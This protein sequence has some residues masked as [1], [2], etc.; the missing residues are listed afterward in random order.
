MGG[1]PRAS[2][3][4][5]PVYW[6]WEP[7]SLRAMSPR[8]CRGLTVLHFSLIFFYI[9]IQLFISPFYSIDWLGPSYAWSEYQCE[10]WFWPLV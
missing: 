3:P 4:R 1:S 9:C 10:L 5:K 8:T 6:E 2:K 7:L